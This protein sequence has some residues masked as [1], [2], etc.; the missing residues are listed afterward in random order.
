MP[1]DHP[2]QRYPS[3]HMRKL[4]RH[5]KPAGQ[6]QHPDRHINDH[7][8][9]ETLALN[10]C[11]QCDVIA[12]DATMRLNVDMKST[13]TAEMATIGELAERFGLATH[14]LRHWESAGL[15]APQRMRNG[16]RRYGPDDVVRVAFIRQ[17]KDLGFSLDQIRQVIAAT[18][19]VSRRS[20][21]AEHQAALERRIA[22]ALSAKQAIEHALACPH[23]D[24]LQ[25]S[26]IR[27]SIIDRIPN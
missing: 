8:R 7:W 17:G 3:K 1:D 21:L 12:H 27:Q 9:Q 25:C 20:V 26:D 13:A 19:P 6:Q 11:S 2:D 14:V 23:R 18:D 16:Q 10:D 15:L 24:F 4:D 22:D 5:G